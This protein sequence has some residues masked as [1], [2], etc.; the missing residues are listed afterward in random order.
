MKM[1]ACLMLLMLLASCPAG[2]EDAALS[3]S[4]FEGGGAEYRVEIEDPEIVACRSS[5]RYDSDEDPLPPGSGFTETFTFTGLKPGT[6][7]VTVFADSPLADSW[8]AAY[9]ATV[10]GSLRVTLARKRAMTRFEYC[11]GGSTVP[12]TREVFL[13]G[14]EYRLRQDD[15]AP[16]RIDG[17]VAAE[18]QRIVEEF[19]MASWDGFSGSNPN[20]L[21]GESFRLDIEFDDGTSVHASGTNAFPDGYRR[22]MDRVEELLE[23][24]RMAYIAGAYRLEGGDFTILLDADGR[25]AFPRDPESGESGAGQWFEYMGAV[26]LA[27]SERDGAWYRFYMEDGALVYCRSI[28]DDLPGAQV[29]EGAR[30]L[31]T[32]A[33]DAMDAETERPGEGE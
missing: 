20:V 9:T 1:I 7:M 10:D 15:E 19:D 24:E 30:F 17:A 29:G 8:S 22:A 31:R 21:D 4:S 14:G 3:F 13:E 2:A 27:D 5:R 28:S 11:R 16:R 33:A 12:I 26:E 23:S 32:A 25:F 18:L 6:T